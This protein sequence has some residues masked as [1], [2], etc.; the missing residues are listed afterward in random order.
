MANT[1]CSTVWHYQE[2]FGSIASV[3][4]LQV[5]VSRQLQVAL[6]SPF[7]MS[8]QAQLLN[9]PVQALCF[10]TLTIFTAGRSCARRQI[11]TQLPLR[12]SSFRP[13]LT[14]LVLSVQ[15]TWEYAPLFTLEA[16]L[17]DRTSL[18]Q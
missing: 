5:A 3:T 8:R 17:P 14:H 15:L 12:P 1:P 13:S 6:Q 18:F 4:V 11:F 7:C 2:E 9:V 16:L 10:G